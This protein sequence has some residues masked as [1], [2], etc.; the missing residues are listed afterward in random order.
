MW[1]LVEAGGLVL[2]RCV[3]KSH[4]IYY[5]QVSSGIVVVRILGRQDTEGAFRS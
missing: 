4:S 1:P 3:Y 2:R 5:R